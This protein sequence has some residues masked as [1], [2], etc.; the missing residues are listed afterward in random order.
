M[1]VHL[2]QINF[3]A[4]DTRFGGYNAQIRFQVRINPQTKEE[5]TMEFEDYIAYKYV[6]LNTDEFRFTELLARGLS[7]CDLVKENEVAFSAGII[8]IYP[9]HF[10]LFSTGSMTLKIGWSHKSDFPL[11][12]KIIGKEF[13]PST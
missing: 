7:H 13:K 5:E 4:E 1:D 2:L 6:R 9:E 10:S 3:H 8:A 12:K 11:L